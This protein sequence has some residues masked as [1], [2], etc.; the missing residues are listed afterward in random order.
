MNVTM[1]HLAWSDSE[2]EDD[3]DM[4]DTS[5][6]TNG[7]DDEP[8]TEPRLPD[9]VLTNTSGEEPKELEVRIISKMHYVA[10]KANTIEHTRV[11]FGQQVAGLEE[12]KLHRLTKKLKGEKRRIIDWGRQQ[13]QKKFIKGFRQKGLLGVDGALVTAIDDVNELLSSTSD[14]MLL[15]KIKKIVYRCTYGA[16]GKRKGWQVMLEKEYMSIMMWVYA[17]NTRYVTAKTSKARGCIARLMSVANQSV[18]KK[19][20]KDIPEDA[21][22][23]KKSGKKKPETTRETNKVMDTEASAQPQMLE[24]DEWEPELP[25]IMFE[26]NECDEYPPSRDIFNTHLVVPDNDITCRDAPQKETELTDK[27]KTV[28]RTINVHELTSKTFI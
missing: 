7:S 24:Y 19:I 12:E 18:M 1:H 5:N 21:Q 4:S 2:Y 27:P 26:E 10:G 28:V 17:K 14:K 9:Q 20:N 16:M 25:G 23:R 6:I 11:L 3:D 13:L 22:I 8:I 15:R